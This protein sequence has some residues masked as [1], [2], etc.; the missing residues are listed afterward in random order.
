MAPTSSKPSK[1]TAHRGG[2]KKYK[3]ESLSKEA[4]AK[5]LETLNKTYQ[6][7]IK[8]YKK[9]INH[10][11]NNGNESL[12]EKLQLPDDKQK[13]ISVEGI[14]S[15]YKTI[16]QPKG[17][18]H[19]SARVYINTL[20]YLMEFEKA[21]TI[22]G[23]DITKEMIEKNQ[24]FQAILSLIDEHRKTVEADPKIDHLSKKTATDIV[25]QRETSAVMMKLLQTETK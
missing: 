7:C 1:P 16:V 4:A 14:L 24:E 5:K 8:E 15:F 23:E 21:K 17:I 22:D 18:T 25:S 11:R 6:G 10:I 12:K 20:H 2:N 9:F 3:Y 19:H 13:Y